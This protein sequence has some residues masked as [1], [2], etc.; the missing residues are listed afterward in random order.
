MQNYLNLEK[1]LPRGSYPVYLCYMRVWKRSI[2]W[3]RKGKKGCSNAIGLGPYR[4]IY[5]IC[6]VKPSDKTSQKKLKSEKI[7]VLSTFKM[8]KVSARTAAVRYFLFEKPKILRAKKNGGE[9]LWYF[10]VIFR[11]E[12]RITHSFFKMI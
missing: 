7:F 1:F 8:S 12:K 11:T 2:K 9:K 10:S 6:K 5:D 4:I 3:R